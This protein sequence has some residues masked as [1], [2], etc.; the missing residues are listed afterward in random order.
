MIDDRKNL[1][2]KVRDLE[3][4]SRRNNLQLGGLSQAQGKDWHRSEAKIKRLM[5]KKLRIENVEIER[6][7]RINKEDDPSQKRTIIIKSLNAK[8]KEKVLR[9]HRP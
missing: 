3:D 2:V 9:E 1:H 5:K 7:H 4:R 8:D 6:A